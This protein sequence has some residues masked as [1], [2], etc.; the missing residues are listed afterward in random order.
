MVL[1]YFKPKLFLKQVPWKKKY[2][3]YISDH[4]LSEWKPETF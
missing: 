2:S 3:N 1:H 4:I